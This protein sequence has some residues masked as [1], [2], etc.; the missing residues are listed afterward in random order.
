MKKYWGIIGTVF[1]ALTLAGC[2]NHSQAK[3]SDSKKV[4]THKVVKKSSPKK[5]TAAKTVTTKNNTASSTSTEFSNRS[6]INSGAEYVSGIF[7]KGDQ[8]IWKYTAN[9]SSDINSGKLVVTQG[10]YSYNSNTK[11]VTLNVKSQSKTYT[12]SVSQLE[13][14]YYDN[15][16]ASPANSTLKLKYV[17][18]QFDEMQQ[19]DGNFGTTPMEDHGNDNVNIN[20]DNVI[21]KF[22]VQKIDSSMQKG[23]NAIN[24]AQEFEDF[25]VK[26]KF[27][28]APDGVKFIASNGGDKLQFDTVKVYESDPAVDPDAQAEKTVGIKYTVTLDNGVAGDMIILGTDNNVYYGTSEERPEVT[29]MNDADSAYHMYYG[30]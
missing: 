15:V 19:L 9:T 16:S 28:T 1:V 22:N 6:F 25:L 4:T 27:A 24:S 26:N 12:G 3:S 5:K 2:G 20:Y 30:A 14:Y 13:R 23:K 7:F 8:F 11:I 17:P 21:N 29:L 10:T 18:G